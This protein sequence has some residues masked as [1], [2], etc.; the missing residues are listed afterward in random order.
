MVDDILST[1]V[2]AY[3]GFDRDAAV[4]GRFPARIDDPELRR[5]VVDIVAEVDA[6]AG[7]GTGE[8]LSAW[9]DAL[10]AGVRERHPELS[11]EAL[12]ALKAL[13]TFEYR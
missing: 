9:G 3:V 6:D 11:D 1:A 12:A 4:P 2:L 5:R 10:A 7:P 8:N 13:L